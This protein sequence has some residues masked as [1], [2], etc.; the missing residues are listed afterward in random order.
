M[1]A[2]LDN[3][4]FFK[5]AFTDTFVLKH[6]VKDVLEMDL[7]FDKVETEKSFDPRIGNIDFKY[8][9]FAE[10][11]DKRVIIEI[12]KVDYDYNFDRF[13]HYFLMAIAELQRSSKNYGIEKT[14]YAVIFI[15]APYKI[16]QKTGIP[17][18]DELLISNLN[19]KNI[20]GDELNI[21]GHSL[22]FL[23][24]NYKNAEIPARIRDWLD[25][26]Y[27]SMHHPEKPSI[28]SNNDG[29]KRASEI[30]DFEHISPSE[31]EQSKIREGRKMVQM[32]AKEEGVEEGKIIGRE[33]G[34]QEEKER[35]EKE[36]EDA[37][38]KAISKRKLTVEEI[39]EVF[40]VSVEFVKHL[41]KGVD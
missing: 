14:V 26:V 28:N 23:N 1:I 7:E 30:L 9:I 4:V 19:P 27:E 36:K 2:N 34:K 33:E 15:T 37:I 29:I 32:M 38:R 11:T 13:L 16:N 21:Y 35:S 17:I 10:S 3:E 6:F 12:Q 20:K 25:L 41:P 5:K 31:W 22:V 18:K 40:G 39:A 24:P 8:D